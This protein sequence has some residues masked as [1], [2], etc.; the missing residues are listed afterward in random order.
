MGKK[1]GGSV[2]KTPVMSVQCRFRKFQS[3]VTFVFPFFGFFEGPGDRA[4]RQGKTPSH[5][6]V[7]RGQEGNVCRIKKPSS[8][9]R[10]SVSGCK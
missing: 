5:R 1:G 3:Q 7:P 6:Q 10:Q 8:L 9:P 2:R 4:I